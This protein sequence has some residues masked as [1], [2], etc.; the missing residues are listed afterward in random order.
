MLQASA[1]EGG[2][3]TVLRTL[4][5]TRALKSRANPSMPYRF[6]RWE[7]QIRAVWSELAGAS[8]SGSLGPSRQAVRYAGCICC[9]A[10]DYLLP[11]RAPCNG[12]SPHQ[13]PKREQCGGQPSH[14]CDAAT[15]ARRESCAGAAGAQHAAVQQR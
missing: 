15:Q 2:A 11:V 3:R 7:K 14:C 10:A 6:D 9:G 13:R 8:S 12:R 5:S 1:E 4:Q